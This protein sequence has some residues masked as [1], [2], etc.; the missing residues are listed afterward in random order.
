[1][2]KPK[3][4]AK[5]AVSVIVAF[6]ALAGCGNN[7]APNHPTT[8]HTASATHS[9]PPVP[10]IEG[11]T[12]VRLSTAPVV[13][14]SGLLPYLQPVFENKTGYKLEI[15]SNSSDAAIELGASGGADCLLVQADEQ[16][17][18]FIKDGFGVKSF[19]FMRNY[20]VIIG[21]KNDPAKVKEAKSAAQAF[22][23][24]AASGAQFV[25]RGDDSSVHA[26][27]MKLWAAAKIRPEGK[28][29]YVSAG[30]GMGSSLRQANERDAYI[31]AEKT[32]FLSM[33]QSLDLDILLEKDAQLQNTYAI[34]AVSPEKLDDINIEGANAFVN[35]LLSNEA[36]Q[37]ISEYGKSQFG[38]QLFYVLDDREK[39]K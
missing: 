34:I 10:S 7:D 15:I 4:F 23:A 16:E 30:A 11:N 6:V 13:N 19:P 22:Q 36:A 27:E 38:E 29:F 18:T 31:L 39:A 28:D 35:W 12:I 9:I 37:L 21:P 26:V 2:P 8:T 32:T 20:F 24:I 5:M 17:K 14:D 3:R 33:K 25:S 1:M